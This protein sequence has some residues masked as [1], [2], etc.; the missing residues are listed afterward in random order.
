M[1]EQITLINEISKICADNNKNIQL[2]NS[3][4]E[5]IQNDL[6]SINN[7]HLLEQ[8]QWKQRDEQLKIFCKQQED[9]IKNYI[10]SKTLE[11]QK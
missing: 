3:K 10:N 5:N 1:D 4:I 6:M 8:E 2:N 7:T 9:N 11:Q